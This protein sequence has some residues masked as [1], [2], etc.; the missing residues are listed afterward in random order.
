MAAKFGGKPLWWDE[1]ENTWKGREVAGILGRRLRDR[2]ILYEVQWKGTHEAT[3]ESPERLR[4]LGFEMSCLALDNRMAYADMAL[5]PLTQRAIVEHMEA[6]GITEHMAC[7][8]N[9]GSFSAG[10][11][12][13]LILAAA[14]WVKPHV[15][16][17]DE[18]TNYLDSEI[19]QGLVEAIRGF[20]GGVVVSSHSEAFLRDTCDE[21]WHMEEGRVTVDGRKQSF[22]Q[23]LLDRSQREK[24]RHERAWR[25]LG[26]AAC[27]V[28]DAADL[29]RIL[30]EEAVTSAFH[31]F[32]GK[33]GG[34]PE[35]AVACG[36]ETFVELAEERAPA[37]SED[38]LG[39]VVA[40][41]HTVESIGY[42]LGKMEH[43]APVLLALLRSLLHSRAIGA[44]DGGEMLLLDHAHAR[45][46]W[47][48]R[49]SEHSFVRM[50]RAL[51]FREAAVID[52]EC[53][54][55]GL[56]VD[57]ARLEEHQRACP[58]SPERCGNWLADGSGRI[59]MFHGTSDRCAKIIEREGFKPST[60]GM[61]GP[62]VYCS[63]DLRKARHYGTVVFL[64]HVRLGRVLKIATKD[65]PLRLIW[66]TPI[67]GLYDCA[68]VPPKCGVVPSGLEENCVRSPSQIKV[69]R[70]VQWLENAVF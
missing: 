21:V 25:E 52:Q 32:I 51:R 12:S 18:P 3:L 33:S 4:L 54:Y 40:A 53:C 65:H 34:L 23:R 5:Q 2:E 29:G 68:W 57:P 56:S 17:L 69:V 37:S 35:F 16:L 44:S 62:G 55:C 19:T 7:H 67:G 8:Q 70:R 63:R 15:L 60:S 20:Q 11:K 36:V 61:L 47:R 38:W 43:L 24:L 10:Q 66:Q 1:D 48:H 46:A 14:I 27:W 9:M 45:N 28:Y 22:V 6:F 49:S 13:R 31:R 59:E 58:M 26:Q 41:A 30:D 42:P 64:L 50:C 39:V